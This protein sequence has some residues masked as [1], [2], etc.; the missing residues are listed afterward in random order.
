[1]KTKAPNFYLFGL[2]ILHILMIFYKRLENL[3]PVD[4]PLELFRVHLG[5]FLPKISK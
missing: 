4:S 3:L 2:F 5:N 1:M